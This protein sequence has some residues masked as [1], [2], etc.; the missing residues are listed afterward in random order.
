MEGEVL[1]LSAP[2]SFD[3][4]EEQAAAIAFFNAAY[5][6]E[7]S[8]LRQAHELASE[9]AA[10][11]PDLAECL[12]LYGDEEGWHRQLLVQFLG[13]LGGGVRPMGPTTRTFYRLY[14]RAKRMETIV[15]VNLLFETIGATTYRLALRRATHPA[16]RQMLTILTRDESFHVPLNVHFLREALAGSRPRRARLRALYHGTALALVASTARSRKRAERFDRIP[17][18][19]LARA[20]AEELARLFLQEPDLG[21]APSPLFLRAFGLD[22]RAL[23]RSASP[24][25]VEIAE[26]AAEREN[27]VV[28]PY[29]LDRP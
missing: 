25:S 2:A 4:P 24:V 7:E 28:E 21:L 16:V 22:A 29:R 6:A 17:A 8:G 5:R 1:D 11:D 3:S 14:G 26:R 18:Q 15:L 12:R 19:V 23:A 20:Y 9:V 10:R 27:V 13:W